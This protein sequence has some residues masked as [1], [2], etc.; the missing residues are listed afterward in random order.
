VL[1]RHATN[2]PSRLTTAVETRT[3]VQMPQTA[4]PVAIIIIV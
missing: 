4:A 1:V 2:L 3:L